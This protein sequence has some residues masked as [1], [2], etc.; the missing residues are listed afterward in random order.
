[1][2]RVSP[3]LIAISLTVAGVAS[4]S[5]AP[6]QPLPREKLAAMSPLLEHGEVALLESKQ[7]GEMR[8]VTVVSLVAAPPDRVRA[9]LLAPEHWKEWVRNLRCPR[10]THQKDGAVDC[11]CDIDLRLVS[12]TAAN[13]IKQ[14]PDGDLAVAALSPSDPSSYRWQFVPVP[15]GT[16]MAQYGYTDVLHANSFI[17][18]LVHATP[19][20]EHGLALALQ[21]FFV[22]VVKSG[23]ERQAHE[24]GFKPMAEPAPKAPGFHFLL[25]RGRVAVVRSTPE[26]RLADISLID[27]VH[28]PLAKVMGVIEKPGDY[29]DIIDG[30]KQSYEVKR[31]PGE[32]IFQLELDLSIFSWSGRFAMRRAG[33][34]V[35]EQGLAG[36]LYGAHYR[37]DLTPRGADAT[38]VVFRANQNLAAASPL[39]LGALFREQPQ[40]EHGLS[41]AFGLLQVSGIRGRAEGRK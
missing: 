13:H 8:Q 16:V 11:D 38:Q 27:T 28:A 6:L 26:G 31:S 2:P 14:L 39:L 32:L 5:E 4:A 19:G 7:D 1:M 18:R 29:R 34:A 9:V 35:D 20:L 15:G 21:L 22:H 33:N 30:V 41:V 37:W 17:Q 36:D 40:F 24:A 25:E 10:V 23:A 12:L 3:A